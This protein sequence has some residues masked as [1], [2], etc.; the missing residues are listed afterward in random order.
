[1]S[2]QDV[3]NKYWEYATI[4]NKLED[5]PRSCLVKASNNIHFRTFSNQVQGRYRP[6]QEDE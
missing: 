6:R 5:V 4:I 2:L 1:M 3:N